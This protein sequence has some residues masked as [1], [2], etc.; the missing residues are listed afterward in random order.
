MQ[1]E[2]EI[3]TVT[4]EP[5]RP[6]NGL[7]ATQEGVEHLVEAAQV[8][9]KGAVGEGPEE[10]EEE[11]PSGDGE[12]SP[13]LR[14]VVWIRAKGLGE[15]L[16]LEYHYED[17]KFLEEVPD[18]LDDMLEML[19]DSEALRVSLR[20]FPQVGGRGHSSK[21]VCFKKNFQRM[22]LRMAQKVVKR[23]WFLLAPK[24]PRVS[25]EDG[26][27]EKPP[28]EP[29]TQEQMMAAGMDLFGTASGAAQ[30]INEIATAQGGDVTSIFKYLGNPAVMKLF[31]DDK[32]FTLISQLFRLESV[33]EV[34][35]AVGGPVSQIAFAMNMWQTM[36]VSGMPMPG[37]P[38]PGG[39]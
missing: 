4:E 28:R 38:V 32:A 8:I 9:M 39:G 19:P 37:M 1:E 14:M 10:P 27:R 17:E 11:L 26:Q 31:K 2:E 5:D 6:T 21:T 34:V 18:D 22:T 7:N 12:I 35:R 33:L 20:I 23:Y 15:A 29:I 25:G 30:A 16:E 36:K 3:E 24:D 13:F